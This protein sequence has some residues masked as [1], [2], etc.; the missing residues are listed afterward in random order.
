MRNTCSSVQLVMSTYDT[1][2]AATGQSIDPSPRTAGSD[3][4]HPNPAV[5]EKSASIAS[6]NCARAAERRSNG[7]A[8]QAVVN[9]SDGF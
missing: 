9:L 4:T 1:M 7:R 6:S 5:T 3:G 8:G 2:Y